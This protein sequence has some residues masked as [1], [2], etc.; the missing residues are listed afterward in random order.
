MFSSLRLV[1]SLALICFGMTVVCQAQ[2]AAQN[3]V[4]LGDPGLTSGISGKGVLTVE[5]IKSWLDD[6][7]NHLVLSPSLPLGLAVGEKQL[8]IPEDNPMTRAKV[9]LGPQLYFDRRLSSNNTVS[10]ADCHH[11]EDSY[12]RGTRFGVGINGQMGGRNS[13]VSFNRILSKAVLGWSRQL[14]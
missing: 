1:T 13:P 12:G 9:E 5:E 6:E 4:K 3:K 2:E 14:A 10:C 11:P 7:Q 8:Y